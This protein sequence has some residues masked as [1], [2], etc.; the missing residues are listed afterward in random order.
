MIVYYELKMVFQGMWQ[1]IMNRL[2]LSPMRQSCT[3]DG[4]IYRMYCSPKDIIYTKLFPSSDLPVFGEESVYGP[5]P[6]QWDRI[7]MKFEWHPV[8]RNL[9]RKYERDE[10]SDTIIQTIEKEGYKKQSE[11]KNKRHNQRQIGPFSVS[12]EVI[13]AM[14]RNGQLIHLRGGRH[15]LSA[16]KI[17]NVATIPVILTIYHPKS[18]SHLP[19]NDDW[20]N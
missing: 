14:D 16:A 17:L 9:K 1:F 2:L 7:R 8:Y 20:E 10:Y 3:G 5:V 18:S 6:G 11:V 19:S 12:D 13:V 15:R 4:E